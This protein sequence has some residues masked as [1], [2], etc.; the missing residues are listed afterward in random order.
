[1]ISPLEKTAKAK[2]VLIVEDHTLLAQL[3]ADVINSLPGFIVVARATGETEALVLCGELNPDVMILDLVLAK[4]SGLTVLT[5]LREKGELPKVLVC[6]GNLTPDVVREALEIGAVGLIDKTARLEE[7]RSALF[8]VAS[9][10]T[11]FGSEV[12]AML[13]GLVVGQPSA[14]LAQKRRLTR[15]EQTVL[16]YVIQG[17]TSREIAEMLGVSFY[18][19]ANHRSRLLRKFGLHRATQLSLY[20]TRRNLLPRSDVAPQPD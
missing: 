5:K 14:D 6:S 4:D 1:M 8:A 15:R 3:L 20:A 17:M 18:T 2:R 13:K 12:A 19:V 10:R 11:Y 9:G 7:F 16:T